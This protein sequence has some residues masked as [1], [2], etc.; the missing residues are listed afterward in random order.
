MSNWM[1]SA[2]S[3]FDE[4]FLCAGGGAVWRCTKAFSLTALTTVT[5]SRESGISIHRVGKCIY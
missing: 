1:Y 3:D 4:Y 2:M 5:H